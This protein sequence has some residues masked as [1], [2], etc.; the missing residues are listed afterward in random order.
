[1]AVAR[2]EDALHHVHAGAT[3]YF[4]ST[5]CLEKFRRDP[6]AVLEGRGA[7]QAPADPE[8]LY[9]C[10]MHPEIEERGP[11][12]CPLCG[13]ALEPKEITLDDG[14]N[15][16]LEDMQQRFRISAVLT[17]PLVALVMGEHLAGLRLLTPTWSAWV[18]LGLSAPVVLWGGWPF[19]ERGWASVRTRHLNMF[20]LIAMGTGAAFLFSL[21]AT[22]LPG[23]F[24]ASFRDAS[25]ALPVYYEAA[26]VIVTLVLL[27]QVLE[28]RARERTGSALRALLDLTPKTARLVESDGS[29]REVPAESLQPGDHVLLR[30]GEKVPADGRVVDGESSIDESMLTGEAVA[31]AKR[32]GDRVVGGTVNASGSLVFRVEKVGRETVLAQIVQLVGNAQR[33]RAPVQRLADKAAA[34]LVPIV[35]LIAVASFAA[36]AVLGPPPAFAYALIAAVSVLIIACPCALGLATPMSIMVAVGRGAGLGILVKEAEALER[37][38]AADTLLIDKTGTLTEGR[39]SVVAVSPAEGVSEDRLLQVAASLEQ[40]SEHPLAA[41]VLAAAQARGLPVT[42]LTDFEAVTGKGVQG[43]LEGAVLRAGSIAW[44][45]HLGIATGTVDSVISAIESRGQTVIAVAEDDRL[46]GLIAI[47]DALKPTSPQAISDLRADGLEVVLVSGDT[48]AVAE[49]IAG[50]LGITRIVADALPADKAA[51]VRQFQEQGHIVAMAGDGINDGPALAQA[52]IGVAMGSGTDVAIEAAGITLLKGDL[53]RLYM[54]R[55]LSRATLGNTRQNLFFAF[56]Y[57]G[58][59]VPLAAGVLFPLT[60]WLLSPMFAAA[61]MSLSS[62]SVIGNALRLGRQRF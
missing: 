31:Q 2:T 14:P 15:P 25:G 10:P 1:M 55:R 27:G 36:W 49:A 60:G 45:T 8:A 26:A 58:L 5:H 33:S 30:P 19:F 39:P 7:P 47:A 37:L 16:E 28:L 50:D 53:G 46:L 52:D 48:Q 13:M 51:L 12:S 32:R 62:V 57:N 44:L 29:H 59:G 3:H 21:A 23:V 42:P 41:A 6:E 38:S 22:T 24:P 11:A 61:A 40:R 56:L 43:R 20:T 9:T 35:V 17:L 4:C 18:Q 54:A 34:V